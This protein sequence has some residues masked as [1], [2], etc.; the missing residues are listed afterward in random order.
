[1]SKNIRI[2]YKNWRGETREREII[3][4]SI[5]FGSTKWHPDEQWLLK[6]IDVEKNE[7][8]DF[9][10]VNIMNISAVFEQGSATS[11]VV[12]NSTKVTSVKLYGDG[13]S[14]GNPGPSASGFVIL[15]MDDNV[16]LEKGIYLGITTNNQAEYKALKFGLETALEFGAREV[17]VHMDS[18]LVINQL[19]GLF[20]VKNQDLLPI[21]EAIK[22]LATKFDVVTYTH[23]PRERN[24]L[25]DAEVNKTLDAEAGRSV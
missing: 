17:A 14:R 1:M 12:D 18:L 8:R 21:Y 2:V 15:D 10:L 9:Q 16:L 24:K 25:A 5:W 7:E 11:D 20:K 22:Q 19:K 4:Q 6:A 23:V 13:G 3:P